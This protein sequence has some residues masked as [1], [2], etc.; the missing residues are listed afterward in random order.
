M[1]LKNIPIRSILVNLIVM[2]IARKTGNTRLEGLIYDS[3]ANI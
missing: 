3:V 2:C 1:A